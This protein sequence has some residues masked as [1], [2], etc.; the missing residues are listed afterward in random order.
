MRIKYLF[1]IA[2]LLLISCAKPK[3]AKARLDI[4]PLKSLTDTTTKSGFYIKNIGDSVLKISKATA[5]CGCTL[6]NL[7]KELNIQSNNA[8]YI[9]VILSK[10]DATDKKKKLI[11]VAIRTNSADTGIITFNFKY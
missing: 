1:Y 5:S 8:A 2:S 9:P 3:P 7:D 10:K 4:T 6:I 11:T